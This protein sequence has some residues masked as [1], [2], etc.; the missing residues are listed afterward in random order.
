[1]QDVHV[2]PLSLR[3]WA[4]FMIASVFGA[5]L[6]DFMS[7]DLALGFT[8]RMLALLAVLVAIFTFEQYDRSKTQ[9]WYWTAIIVIQA[10]STKLADF[11][12]TELGFGRFAVIAGLA[13]LLAAT[14]VVA[15]SS[16]SLLISTHMISR[17]GRAAKP[18]AD[19]AHWVAMV[20]AST[21]GSV[22]A[23]AFTIGLGLGALRSSV[24]LMALTAV[25]VSLQRLPQANRL[26]IYWLTVAA[27]RAVG[28][29]VGDVLARDPHLALGLPLSTAM[30]GALMAAVLLLW[31]EPGPRT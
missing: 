8:F 24:I 4:V 6:G 20:V 14:F 25:A 22:A 18:M 9:A 19:S 26:L 13:V 5:N 1:M 15:R 31:R 23:D 2:P 28:N 29:A 21:L 12:T 10:A 30:T 27:L 7:V 3:S 16:P 11:S 17:P